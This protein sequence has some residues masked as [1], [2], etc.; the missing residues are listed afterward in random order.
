MGRY[1]HVPCNGMLFS[2]GRDPSAK[3][4]ADSKK[5]MSFTIWVITVVDVHYGAGRH[6]V[7]LTNPKDTSYGLYLN[8]ITQPM[9]LVGVVLVKASIGFFLYRLTPSQFFHRFIIC[10][11]VFMAVYTT[12]AL[13]ER[14]ARI[15]TR[16][17]LNS[18][19]SYDYYAMSSFED[20]L[21][22]YSN[23]LCLLLAKRS[24]SVRL[25]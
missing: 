9:I 24:P 4:K 17:P 20:T 5:A 12:I 16:I 13:G 1:H 3:C 7:Y 2:Y 22:P 6:L 18:S 8:F 11:Q 15:L 21:G 14:K 10:M 23:R 25:L 19:N